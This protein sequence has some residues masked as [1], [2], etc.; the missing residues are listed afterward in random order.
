[1]LDSAA[2]RATDPQTWK[3]RRK[4][5]EGMVASAAK[6]FAD[7]RR[8]DDPATTGPINVMDFYSVLPQHKYLPRPDPRPVAVGVDRRPTD[9]IRAHVPGYGSGPSCQM[10]WTPSESLVIADRV[11]ADGAGF[12]T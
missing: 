12:R 1:M 4:G 9:Q 5:V 7:P 10:T 11:V 8:K 6:K 3:L 2:R